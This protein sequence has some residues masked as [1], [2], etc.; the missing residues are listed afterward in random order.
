MLGYLSLAILAENLLYAL[1]YVMKFTATALVLHAAA[2]GQAF[3]YGPS[4]ARDPQTR[5]AGL[6][7]EQTE[8]KAL[9]D[10]ILGT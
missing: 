2:L 1:V 6:V 8:I 9:L 3:A 10:S 5:E 4:V 7:V